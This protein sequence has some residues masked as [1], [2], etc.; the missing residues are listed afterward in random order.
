M[1]GRFE[2]YDRGD[3]VWAAFPTHGELTLVITA[4]PYAQFEANKS[5]VERHCLD[6]FSR[7]PAF[8]DRLHQARREAKFAGAAVPNVFRKPFGPGWALVGDAGYVKDPLTAQG[9]SDAFRDAELCAAAVDEALSGR[10]PFDDALA[11][12]QRARDEHVRAMYQFTLEFAS[13]APPTEE[14]RQLYAA[15]A[16]NAEAME[17][18]I[19]VFTGVRSPA[20][21][22][23]DDNVGRIMAAANG[24]SL[25]T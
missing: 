8:A 24:G 18:F 1:N 3:R 13:F 10:R 23:S 15:M 4:W 14:A 16:G 22:F 9:I 17:G 25:P 21:F 11:G 19:Q 6:A 2:A 12:Y 20:D 7:A 5:D